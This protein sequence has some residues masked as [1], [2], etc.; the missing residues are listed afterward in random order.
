MAWKGAEQYTREQCTWFSNT[1]CILVN[2]DTSS[3]KTWRFHCDSKK[4]SVLPDSG[5]CVGICVA[6]TRI[7]YS[8]WP[9][10]N[11][12][13]GASVKK[14][15]VLTGEWHQRYQRKIPDKAPTMW[16]SLPAAAGWGAR[17]W[18]AGWVFRG[19]GL[20]GSHGLWKSKPTPLV[21]DE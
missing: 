18:G 5:E 1:A 14:Q 7:H 4:H 12:R 10:A 20:T 16:A 21:S 11:K 6:G 8:Y 17:R 9:K 13:A 19:T 15:T 2:K 3:V